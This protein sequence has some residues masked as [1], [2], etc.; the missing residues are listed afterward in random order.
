[1]RSYLKLPFIAV[2]L[3]LALPQLLPAQT[4]PVKW[5]WHKQTNEKYMVALPSTWEVRED[6]TMGLYKISLA[7]IRP[8]KP[9]DEFREN[10]NVVTEAVDPSFELKEYVNASITGM[11]KGLT[12]FQVINEGELKGGYTPSRYLVYTQVAEQYNG[13]LKAVVFFYLSGG[14]AYSLTCTATDKTFEAYLPLFMQMGKSFVLP[15]PETT[16]PTA[17]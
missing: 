6:V 5:A 1:M 14:K 11:T 9:N 16:A 3:S 12:Q 4:P 13:T 7:S 8:L 15:K 2:L 17:Q 10:A